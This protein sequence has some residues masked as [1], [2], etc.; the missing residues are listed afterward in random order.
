MIY[1]ILYCRLILLIHHCIKYNDKLNLCALLVN[2]SLKFE[3]F[4]TIH[5]FVP[6]RLSSFFK[7]IF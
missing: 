2:K 6:N 4:I 5:K 1:K 3:L 7:I